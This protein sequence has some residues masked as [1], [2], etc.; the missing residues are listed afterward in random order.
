MLLKA[1]PQVPSVETALLRVVPLLSIISGAYV[2]LG[3]QSTQSARRSPNAKHVQ[4]QFNQVKTIL[5]TNDSF[6]TFS[7]EKDNRQNEGV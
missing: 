3:N 2:E 6:N 1:S 7:N 4:I 5:C